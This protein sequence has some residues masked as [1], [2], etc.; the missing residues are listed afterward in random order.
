MV[1]GNNQYSQKIHLKSHKVTSQGSSVTSTQCTK[2][3]CIKDAFHHT[4]YEDI[5]RL[6][7]IQCNIPQKVCFP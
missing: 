7:S 4:V 2:Q 5:D 3:R 6:T 1:I